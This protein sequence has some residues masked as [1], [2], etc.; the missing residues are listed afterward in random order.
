MPGLTAHWA[1]IWDAKARESPN[2]SVGRGTFDEE[3]WQALA[4][5]A[6]R[7]LELSPRTTLLD[8]GCGTGR[9]GAMLRPRCLNYLGIDYSL[10]QL[11]RGTGHRARADAT[12]LPLEDSCFDRVLLSGVLGS[13]SPEEGLLALR[14]ARRVARAGGRCAVTGIL[15]RHVFLLT[16]MKENI[17]GPQ[18][19]SMYYPEQLGEMG[20][21][22]GWTH[23][24]IYAIDQRVVFS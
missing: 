20:G 17:A 1:P 3:G 22:A 16:D 12:R 5:S 11:R 9:L 14:E 19:Q 8:V 23:L 21:E 24:D 15:M 7:M 2:H 10:H 13:I 18:H 4:D 6:A